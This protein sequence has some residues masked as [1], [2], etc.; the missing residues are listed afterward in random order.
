MTPLLNKKIALVYT[1][2]TSHFM[3]CSKYKK[4]KIKIKK[5][6]KKQSIK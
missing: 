2:L 1:I 6:K 4:E 3:L 5:K